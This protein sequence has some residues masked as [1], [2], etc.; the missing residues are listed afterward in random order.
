MRGCKYWYVSPE[1]CVFIRVL[2]AKTDRRIS[3]EDLQIL[4]AFH[5]KHTYF[6]TQSAFKALPY[7]FPQIRIPSIDKMRS[8]IQQLSGLE[9]TAYDCYVNSCCC[10]LGSYKNDSSCPFCKEPCYLG[11]GKTARKKYRYSP[12]IP[13]LHAMYENTSLAK[14]L[15]YR[16][17]YEKPR[18][19]SYSQSTGDS[20]SNI[21][22]TDIWDALIYRDLQ[23][24]HIKINGKELQAKYFSDPRDLALGITTDGFAPW[25]K[26]K[27]TVWPILIIVYNI[28][29]K[30]RF[31]IK[32]I[33]PVSVV[34]GPNLYLL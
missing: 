1:R 11:D 6:L 9:S 15:L 14:D 25:R 2:K 7:V 28:P 19:G 24:R 34:P 23:K 4:R 20:S 13:R 27:Y 5:F 3:D 26:R 31:H 12:L 30:K 21:A 16:H 32:N 18:S 8:R 10:F 17:E 29:P 33:I 22:I